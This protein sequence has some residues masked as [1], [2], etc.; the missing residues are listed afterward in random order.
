MSLLR[1]GADEYRL[2]MSECV[3]L[4]VLLVKRRI[5]SSFVQVLQIRQ[6]NIM[7]VLHERLERHR[8][9]VL[10]GGHLTIDLSST[11]GK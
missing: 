10:N 4:Y 9:S 1:D 6:R 8:D 2:K 5:S 7:C 3:C 11:N